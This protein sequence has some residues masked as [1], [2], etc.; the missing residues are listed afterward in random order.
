MKDT[1][2]FPAA[3]NATRTLAARQHVT[4]RGCIAL[5]AVDANSPV[6]SPVVLS[7]TT[8]NVHHC[9]NQQPDLSRPVTV[10]A[11]TLLVSR[12]AVNIILLQ[13]HLSSVQA[14]MSTGLVGG[15][16]STSTAHTCPAGVS[17]HTLLMNADACLTYGTPNALLQRSARSS[18]KERTP[19][20]SS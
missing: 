1:T 17:P 13:G 19:K 2:V 5:G 11:S 6:L 16:R 14:S 15:R 20:S 10:S 18:V 8:G 7:R 12:V 3:C 9:T 4:P